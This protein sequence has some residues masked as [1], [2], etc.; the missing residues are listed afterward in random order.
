MHFYLEE[1]ILSQ[2]SV[3][4]KA[5]KVKFWNRDMLFL[6]NAKKCIES[7]NIERFAMLNEEMRGLSHYFGSYCDDIDKLDK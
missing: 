2:K 7:N 3:S 1:Y 4:E 5:N 6:Q